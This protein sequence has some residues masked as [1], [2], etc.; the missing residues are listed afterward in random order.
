MI[1]IDKDSFAYQ[2]SLTLPNGRAWR[3]YKTNNDKNNI[4]KLFEAIGEIKAICYHKIMGIMSMLIP[5][6]DNFTA[7]D[8][9]KWEDIM[10]LDSNITDLDSRKQIIYQKMS[11]G[12][13]SRYKLSA[14]YIEHQLQIAGF[15]VFI[16]ENRVLNTT[17]N[18][19]EWEDWSSYVTTT[20]YQYG[21]VE[22]GDIEYGQQKTTGVLANYV[23]ETKDEQFTIGS[24]H[25]YLFIVGGATLGTHASVDSTK[26][27]ALRKLI[28]RLKPLNTACIM[29]VNFV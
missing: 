15:N 23:D 12:G 26:K 18:K 28:L 4:Y 3:L 8:A 1:K 24:N 17:T 11:Q 21:E 6:N 22:Y 7:E 25:A 20:S 16:H 9:T 2:V 19:Y 14:K 29:L 13:N 5:D 27:D 10:A